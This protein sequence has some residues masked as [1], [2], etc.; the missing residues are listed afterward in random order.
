M[1][2]NETKPTMPSELPRCLLFDDFVVALLTSRSLSLDAAVRTIFGY[3]IE[4]VRRSVGHRFWPTATT[5]PFLRTCQLVNVPA[6]Q[7]PSRYPPLSPATPRYPLLPPM[8]LLS[9]ATRRYP[10]LLR[11]YPPLP[12]TLNQ[13]RYPS[14]AT[15]L[16][17]ATPQS[18]P[19][20]GGYYIEML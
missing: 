16:P 20:T 2:L 7:L 10:P 17:T 9:A 13:S 6:S 19:C 4:C 14:G 15:P 3:V 18:F 11:R 1:Q 12:A 5:L 8:W